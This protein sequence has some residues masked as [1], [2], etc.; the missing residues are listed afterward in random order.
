V[1]FGSTYIYLY[2]YIYIS[3]AVDG[4]LWALVTE[5][6]EKRRKGRKK[7]RSKEKVG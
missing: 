4:K 3:P 1:D 2:L 5:K 6:G 7:K